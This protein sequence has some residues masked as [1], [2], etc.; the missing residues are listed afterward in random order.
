MVLVFCAC[1][2]CT[3]ESIPCGDGHLEALEFEGEFWAFK[4]VRGSNLP[5][6]QGSRSKGQTAKFSVRFG[7]FSPTTIEL[8]SYRVSSLCHEFDLPSSVN[9]SNEATCV[10]ACQ[11]TRCVIWLVRHQCNYA[12]RR[13]WHR[14][15]TDAHCFLFTWSAKF[16]VH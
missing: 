2:S 3:S 8:S 4:S 9:A 7:Y 12:R 16:E 5:A 13:H 11:K 14:K 10:R 1:Q 6:C 15:P